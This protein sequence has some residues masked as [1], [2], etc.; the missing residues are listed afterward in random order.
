M[1]AAV[2]A[3]A[4]PH[5]GSSSAKVVTLS[6][7]VA[8]HENGDAKANLSQLLACTDQALYRAKHQGRNRVEQETNASQ[9]SRVRS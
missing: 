1:R 4:I 2:E 9:R 5:Q 8:T 3:L 6:L 7:G